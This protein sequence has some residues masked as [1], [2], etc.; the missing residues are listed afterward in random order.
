MTTAAQNSKQIL[1]QKGSAATPSFAFLGGNTN[2]LYLSGT[3]EMSI[4]LN[5]A[6][7]WTFGTTNTTL[8][9]TGN[10]ILADFSNATITNRTAFQ[11]SASN[12]NTALTVLPSGSATQGAYTAF[13]NSDP[14]NASYLQAAAAST[15]TS[16]TSGLTGSGTYLP[17]AI[18]TGGTENWRF[19][20]AGQLGIGG[21]T[22]G[23]T[24]YVLTSGGA[25]A[26][27][28]WSQV[29]LT[30]GVTGILPPA[31]GGTGIAN[32]AASTLTI[33]GA[34]G[35]TL[36]V[37][38]TTALTLPN[39]GYVISTVTNMAANPV[40]GTPSSSNFLRGDGTWA[41][42]S[43]TAGS[44][45]V[46][47]TT[48]TSGTSGYILYNNAGTLGNLATTGSGSVVLATSPTLT[49]PTIGAATATSVNKVAITAPATSATLTLADGSTLA[50]SGA[51]STTFTVSG[52]TALTLPTSGTVTALG[53]TTT[54]SGSI[55]LAT[56]P[57]LTTPTIGVA[58]ATSVNKV[59]ITA[60]ATSATLTI[61]D[62]KTLTVSN[63]LTLAGT[64]ATTMTFPS[65]TQTIAGL[66]ATQTFTATNTFRQINYTNNAITVATNAATVPITHR[67]NTVTN[68]AAGSVTITM[69]TTSAVDGQMCI[70]RFYDFSAATQTL[71][72][73]NTENSAVSVPT[74]SNGSTT[75]PKTVGFMYNSATNLWRC[76]ASS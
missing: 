3:N 17:L 54:G 14:T 10:R 29:S 36:T 47:T 22:Y 64:D 9:G 38:A 45:V 75:L 5:G 43:T 11:T 61:A 60:P 51:F 13:N 57:T 16:L 24:G 31:N 25:S 35:T 4:A 52:T 26:A 15:F 27:P 74:T 19:G 62:G 28:T 56:S 59:T 67:L 58:T 33:S 73:V 1:A 20:T 68:N 21:A 37:S 46:G 76:V 41:A 48:V 63:S 53:N 34:F 40:T 8:A 32:N 71:S 44:I 7:K 18:F 6:N 69:T 39:S 72:W 65:T 42:P 49:T 12:S 23:T 2:G 66:A 30:A 55:V 50:T 70:V